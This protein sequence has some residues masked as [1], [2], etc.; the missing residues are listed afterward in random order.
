MVKNFLL[1]LLALILLV[2]V[3]NR[4]LVTSI[5]YAINNN[6]TINGGFL[7][8]MWIYKEVFFDKDYQTKQNLDNTTILDIGANVGVFSLWIND[9]YENTTVHSFEPVPDLYKS[10]LENTQKC[11]K[12]N[13]HFIVND[14][15][16]SNKNEDITIKYF[17]NASGLSTAFHD[18]DDKEAAFGKMGNFLEKQVWHV[19]TRKQIDLNVKVRRI[20]DYLVENNINEVSLCKIDVEGSEEN[21]LKGFGSKIN[22]VKEYIIEVENYRPGV[23]DRMKNMLSNYNIEIECDECQWTVMHAVKR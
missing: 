7:S 15:G 14:F 18:I 8:Y 10:T 23:L 16:L 1:T 3:V 13:N 4:W 12:N 2:I 11:Q 6:L 22:I 19:V 5:I 9:N 21:I 17:P 20:E